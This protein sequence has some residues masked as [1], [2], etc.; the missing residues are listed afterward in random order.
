MPVRSRDIAR[1]ARAL[2]AGMDALFRVVAA[3]API[4]AAWL[5]ALRRDLLAH[6][7]SSLILAGPAQPP[8]VHALVHALNDFL[9]NAGQ[10]VTYT[11]SAS[12]ET[13]SRSVRRS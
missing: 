4:D 3:D 12:I 11:H 10:T 9:G 2:A 6:R 1:L 5:D 8:F 13:D 7:G